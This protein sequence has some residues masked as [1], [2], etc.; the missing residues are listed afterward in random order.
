MGRT[1]WNPSSFHD[2]QVWFGKFIQKLFGA[3]NV[4]GIYCICLNFQ[5]R[6][7]DNVMNN[8]SNTVV[9]LWKSRQWWSNLPESYYFISRCDFLVYKDI[10]SVPIKATENDY[11]KKVYD[12]KCIFKSKG[13]ATRLTCM[14]WL[15]N[16]HVL[17]DEPASQSVFTNFSCNI[18]LIMKL[19]G[20][21]QVMWI[22]YPCY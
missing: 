7:W 16:L 11:D 21:K 22:S 8:L 18:Y 3:L 20:V 10:N 4:N 12:C 14:F 15:M 17:I 5:P 9:T 1:S 19:Q 2:V 13:L 6:Q